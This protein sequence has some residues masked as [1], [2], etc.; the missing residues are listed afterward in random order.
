MLNCEHCRSRTVA[1]CVGGVA[2]MCDARVH[3]VKHVLD[4]LFLNI[5]KMYQLPLE[6]LVKS[7]L[8]LILITSQVFNKRR[9]LFLQIQ[10]A[11]EKC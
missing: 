4:V 2:L 7:K 3:A 1:G 5:L 8:V 10:K 6:L 11:V 9:L